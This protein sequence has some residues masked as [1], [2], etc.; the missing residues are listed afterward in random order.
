MA[1]RPKA[2][3]D[4][5]QDLR[6]ALR[7]MRRDPGFSAFTILIAGLGIGAGCTVF[8]VVNALL[9]RP[10]PFQ[11]PA[12]LV[13]M[14]NQDRWTAIQ[15]QHYADLRRLSRSFSDLAGWS[16]FYFPGDQQLTGGG[17]PERVTSVPVTG[18]LFSVLGVAPA[19][20]RVFS[21]EECQGLYSAP[22]ATLL[23]YGFWQRRFAGDS[24]VVGSKLILNHHAVTVVGVLPATFDFASIFA[25]GVP[26]DLFVPWP[27]NDPRKPSGNTMKVVGRLKP[28]AS[29]QGAQAELTALAKELESR[30]PERN[31]IRPVV[32]PLE[33]R[34]SGWVGPALF[35][36]ACAVMAVMSI[37]CANLSNLQL[38]RLAARQ[39]E[40][41]TRAALGAGRWRLV[42]QLLTE[43]VTL[44]CGGAVLGVG[45]AWAGT[46]QVAH[47]RALQLPLLESVRVDGY[48]LLF[49]LLA[50]IGSGVLFGVLPALRASTLSLSEELRDAGRGASAGRRS[51]WVRDGLVVSEIAFAC[52]LLVGAGLLLRSFARVLEVKLGFEPERAAA[53]RVD[54]SFRMS[55][56]PQQNSFLDEMLHRA[57][58]VPG[59]A[60]AGI[61][62]VLPLRDDRAWTVG[63]KGQVY[64]K[65]RQPEA[66]VRVVSDGYFEAAGIPLRMGRP[67]LESDRG[68]SERVVV[69]NETMA[70]ALWPGQNPLGQTITTD[71]GRRVVGVVAD[72]RHKSPEAAGGL[73]MYLPMRQT[74]DYATMQLVLRTTLPPERLAADLRTALR[75][76]DRNLPV[77]EFQT[78]QDLVDRSVSPRRFLVMLLSG[79]AAFALVLASLGI[80][81]VISFS[82][83]QRVQEIGIRMA[84]GASSFDLQL[85]IVLRTLGL[86]GVGLVWGMAASR[87]L[88]ITLES[89]LF[90][91]DSGDPLTFVTVGLLLTGVAAVAGYVPALRA[92]RIDPMAALRSN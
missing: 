67:F 53:L 66:F 18:N 39:K 13:W 75:A 70:R 61:T 60:S 52:I 86:A 57:R 45:L 37:V 42:R 44:A 43:S 72:I 84:L 85:R 5:A 64:Q 55:G 23:S 34:V 89:F 90:G 56:L 35:V 1:R 19:L 81:A 92:S 8:S 6:Y 40:M 46:R 51:A 28:D 17:E 88:S 21:E 30:H 63:A 24:H 11:D 50:A 79:F 73:E 82:V 58:A 41:V 62:D 91:I 12:R 31:P 80:Y 76:V 74:A 26:V 69:V 78:F 36:L 32:M 83:S 54:P 59:V 9:L 65:G 20:G 2:M 77:G 29:V 48:A 49:T 87:A 3:G 27:V 4:L 10:L 25:P 33:E 15:T 14:S 16:G 38:A 68:T 71:G 47:L 7:G 22:P